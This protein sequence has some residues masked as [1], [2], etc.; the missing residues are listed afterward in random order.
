MKLS[1][2]TPDEYPS[3]FATYLGILEDVNLK[4][5]LEISLSDFI[6]FVQNIPMDKFDCR[7]APGK[8][9]I[10]EIIQHLI[11]CERIFCYRALCFSRNDATVLPSFDDEAYNLATQ[12]NARSI[13]D[14]LTEFS[15][16]RYATLSLFKSFSGEQLE[17]KGWVTTNSISVRAIGFVVIGHQKHHQKVFKDYYI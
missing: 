17:R 6:R 16:V 9:T 4:E 10:K 1:Q 5:E 15:T 14:L 7:Y 11:D 8:W 12:A 3:Y 2:L 13:Q